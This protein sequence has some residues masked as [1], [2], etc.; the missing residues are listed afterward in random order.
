[1]TTTVIRT[2]STYKTKLSDY[3]SLV[4]SGKCFVLIRAYKFPLGDAT[5]ENVV[6]KQSFR[7]SAPASASV[8]R[9][10]S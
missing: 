3:F 7:C 1:M 9:A 5:C 4:C 2:A 8:A 6:G 10:C